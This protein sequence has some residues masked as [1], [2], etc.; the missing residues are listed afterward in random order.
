MGNQAL[1]AR[2]GSLTGAS[3]CFTLVEGL[4][5]SEVLARFGATP[6]PEG[7]GLLGEEPLVGVTRAGRWAIALELESSLGADPAVLCALS[8]G[9]RA[10][11]VDR[12]LDSHVHLSLAEDRV[13]VTSLITIPPRTRQ[14]ADPDRLLPVLREVGLAEHPGKKTTVEGGEIG[15]VLDAVHRAFGVSFSARLWQGPFTIGELPR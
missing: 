6:A 7:D 9:T 5:A 3:F 1:R 8:R 13:L 12:V 15:R 2:L 4:A 14:G 11:S 10:V